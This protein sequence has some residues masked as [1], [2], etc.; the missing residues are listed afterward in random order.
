M[1]V[2]LPGLNL[3]RCPIRSESDVGS[4]IAPPISGDNYALV[5]VDAPSGD[6]RF[7]LRDI[8]G[9][10]LRYV[11]A[12]FG[13]PGE[14]QLRID[15]GMAWPDIASVDVTEWWQFGADDL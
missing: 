4:G 15:D 11:L 5:D 9:G 3:I 8:A 10:T 1:Q 7:A 6:G 14:E 13:E 12:I 2:L